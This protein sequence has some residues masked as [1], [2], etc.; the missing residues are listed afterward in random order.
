MLTTS[1]PSS[2]SWAAWRSSGMSTLRRRTE[3]TRCVVGRALAELHEQAGLRRAHPEPVERAG[4]P[5]RP[6]P[7]RRRPPGRRRR[8]RAR[9]RCRARRTGRPGGGRESSASSAAVLWATRLRRQPCRA[10]APWTSTTSPSALSRASDSRPRAPSSQRQAEG[11]QRVLG[12]VGAGAAVGEGDR[13]GH[14]LI[15]TRVAL[16]PP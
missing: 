1:I 11:G 5:G 2:A 7:A 16:G 8:A 10:T 9:S 6:P 14:G 3:C 12:S 4:A 15:V 13:C